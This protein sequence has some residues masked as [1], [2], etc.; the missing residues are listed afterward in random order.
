VFRR[1]VA[2]GPFEGFLKDLV[3][4]LKYGNEK[5]LGPALGGL[6]REAGDLHFDLADYDALVPVPLHPTRLRERGYNQ[7]FL[8][9]RA[10]AEAQGLPVVHALVRCRLG[11]PQV[12]LEGDARRENVAEVFA[13]HPLEAAGSEG[14]SLLLVDDVFTTGATVEACARTLLGSGLAAVVDVLTVARTA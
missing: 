14:L 9:A 4:R 8:L 1:A 13:L 11:L 3:T 6:A 10:V 7:S 2:F 12:G 5:A